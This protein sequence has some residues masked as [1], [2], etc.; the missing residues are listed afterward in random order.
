[1][2]QL[3]FWLNILLIGCSNNYNL[4]SDDSAK[5]EFDQDI[6]KFADMMNQ[7]AIEL[8]CYNTHFVN[9]NG[10][11]DPNHYSSAYDLCLIGNYASKF[12]ELASITK[13]TKYTL[14]STPEYEK[15]SNLV[16]IFE[17]TN[18]LI[19]KSSYGYYK[20]ATGFKTGYTDMAG[21]CIIATATKDNRSLVA[22]VLGSDT[23]RNINT[24]RE[25]DCIR[26][27]EYGFN[28]YVYQPVVTKGSIVSST[29]IINGT[30]NTKNLNLIAKD[31]LNFLMKKEFIID[32]N[33]NVTINK[34]LAPIHAGDIVGALECNVDGI[35]Y[36]VDLIAE[37]DVKFSSTSNI[38]LII[39]II[40]SLLLIFS[41]LK[42][43]R[44]SKS[45][46]KKFRRRKK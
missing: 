19:N 39:I 10:V 41:I 32:I 3:M 14:N 42:A 37:H 5:L 8:G 31:D 4:S 33:R 45:K 12:K 21:Y 24:S 23:Y 27:F 28:E 29:K 15:V 25:N 40:I 9:P 44:K 43:I 30:S 11:H 26:L 6:K 16:R 36:K 18:L 22:V 46:K 13:K 38:I 7:K 2:M 35:N 17:N 20:Y 34:V 1:M